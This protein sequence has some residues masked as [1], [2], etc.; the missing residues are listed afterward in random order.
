MP[1]LK[2]VITGK[3]VEMQGHMALQTDMITEIGSKHMEM[4]INST[5]SWSSRIQFQHY[6]FYKMI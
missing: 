4:A 1:N 6:R 5:V 2:Y 3:V